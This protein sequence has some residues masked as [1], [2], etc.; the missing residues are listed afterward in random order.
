[1]AA[2]PKRRRWRK[3]HR[4]LALAALIVAGM[5]TLGFATYAAGTGIIPVA[6]SVTPAALAV[7]P[8]LADQTTSPGNALPPPPPA[9]RIPGTLAPP[10]AIPTAAAPAQSYRVIA[11]GD[12][13]IGSDWPTPILDARVVPGGD[14][15]AV[16]GPELA[17]LF[18][19]GDVTF[20]NFEGTMH[21]FDA[22]AKNCTNP[23]I[24]FTFRT[25]TWYGEYLRA[26]GFNLMSNANNHANDFGPAGQRETVPLLRQAGMTVSAADAEG[27][28]IDYRV[29]AD[30]TRVALAAFGH[31]VGLMR[32]QDFA[33]V[34]R[35]V[36]EARA[37]SDITVVSCHIGAEGASRE[38]LTR[39]DEAFIGENRG[40]PYAFAH[41]AVDAGASLVLCHGPHV[42]RA[43]EVYKGHLI[44]YSL[45]NFWTYGRFN[46]AGVNS[47]APLLDL[48]VDKQ[49]M[50]VSAR[51]VSAT[52]TRPG[53]PVLDPTNAAAQRIGMLTQADVP[54]SGTTVAPDGTIN[55]PH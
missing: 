22:G 43:V 30:G 3:Q 29:L 33:L 50:L 1:M 32:V 12:V 16:V 35:V 48:R 39:A 40:N 26:A 9:G 24:C 21:P 15:A 8:D 5:S 28:R 27:L 18:K 20:G 11:V 31:N 44:A 46:L 41:V 10:A 17:A 52:Q 51:I 54:E 14:A 13:M 55:W 23:S 36:A 47:L 38:H 49:G 34:H 19:T 37:N 25:P 7:A 4:E 42:S 45:G 6:R 53:G 2:K